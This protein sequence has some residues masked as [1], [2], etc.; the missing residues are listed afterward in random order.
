MMIASGSMIAPLS[1]MMV[2]KTFKM[3][4]VSAVIVC[5]GVMTVC[6]TVIKV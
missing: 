4:C 1:P 6:R 3:S 2:I 5:R